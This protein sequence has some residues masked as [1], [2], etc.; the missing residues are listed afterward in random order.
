MYMYMYHWWW[1]ADIYTS[2]FITIMNMITVDM[3]CHAYTCMY[4]YMCIVMAGD[5]CVYTISCIVC[6]MYTTKECA[7]VYM[8][9][10]HDDT[11]L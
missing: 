5:T 9:S 10:E 2:M 8:S 6:T 4:M 3:H 11:Q 1:V 7:C